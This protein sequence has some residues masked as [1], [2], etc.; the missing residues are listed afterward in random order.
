MNFQELQA[1]VISTPTHWH[2]LQFIGACNKGLHVWQ[3]KPISY[4]IREAQ[5]MKAA[6]DKSGIV[7]N[8]DFPRLHAPINDQVKDY[9]HSG[10]VGEIYQIQAN[11]HNPV[12]A[13]EEGEIPDTMDY[14]R[15]CGPAPRLK[16]LA[17]SRS[18]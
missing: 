2:A 4:D 6:Y 16:Y 1:V 3:E 15:F 9:I 13:A 14:E 10:K 7:V 11:I 8:I 5:A 18:Q 17:T 12:G